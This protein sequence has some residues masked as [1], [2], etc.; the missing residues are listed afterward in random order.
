MADFLLVESSFQISP[1]E[2]ALASRVLSQGLSGTLVAFYLAEHC[3]L[4][5]RIQVKA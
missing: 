5:E 1:C 2:Q 3:V 4:A